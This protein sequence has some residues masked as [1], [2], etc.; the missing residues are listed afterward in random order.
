MNTTTRTVGRPVGLRATG[1][2][3][4]QNG[5]SQNVIRILLVDDHAVIRQALR[6]LLE[7]QPELEVVADVENGREAVQAVEKLQP[8]VVL[9]DV[10]MP[11]L[12]GLEIARKVVNARLPVALII[13]TMHKEQRLFDEAI[14]AGVLQL[15]VKATGLAIP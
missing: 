15:D 2:T 13:L 5:R 11:G 7:N 12:N 14:A 8:D 6:M 10:V 4:S 3:S 9:M 1:T